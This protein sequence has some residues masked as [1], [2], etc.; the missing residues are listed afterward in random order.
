MSGGTPGGRS[1]PHTPEI[2]AKEGRFWPGFSHQGADKVWSHPNQSVR[3]RLLRRN[4]AWSGMVP[5]RSTTQAMPRRETGEVPKTSEPGNPG[6]RNPAFRSRS[7]FREQAG[8]GGMPR[9]KRAVFACRREED[10]LWFGATTRTLA[11]LAIRRQLTTGKRPNGASAPVSRKS[12][13]PYAPP[14]APPA[15]SLPGAWPCLQWNNMETRPFS[16]PEGHLRKQKRARGG[17]RL[18]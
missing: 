17:L 15:C 3:F 16:C 8:G 11:I 1:L 7:P 18:T 6:F 9:G 5:F 2:S 4:R 12:D 14:G 13:L 10:V